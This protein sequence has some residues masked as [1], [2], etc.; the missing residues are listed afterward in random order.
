LL[1]VWVTCCTRLLVFARIDTPATADAVVML[2]GDSGTR[3]PEALRLVRAGMAPELVLSTPRDWTAAPSRQVCRDRPIPR[4]TCFEPD[5]STTRGEAEEIGR[6]AAE[7][8][9]RRV[10]VVTST[11]HVSRA[12]M[13]IRRCYHGEILMVTPGSEHISLK[14]WV[15]QYGYQ[16]AAWLVGQV[17]RSC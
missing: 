14:S 9:W 3:L 4:I 12:R 11:Y 13:I 2:G 6:L 10:I 16:S 5:P 1:V 8:G 15:F 17:Q 7:R